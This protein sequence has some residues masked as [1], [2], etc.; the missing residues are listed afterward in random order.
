[1]GAKMFATDHISLS[2]LKTQ[3]DISR[4][5][6]RILPQNALSV[7]S[8]LVN[9]NNTWSSFKFSIVFQRYILFP[10]YLMLQMNLFSHSFIV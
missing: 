9:A 6:T 4:M 1:M 8:F 2:H 5:V 3:Q 10:C 7:S